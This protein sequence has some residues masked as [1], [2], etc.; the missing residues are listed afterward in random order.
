MP[1]LLICFGNAV[2]RIG[3]ELPRYT[4][5]ELD[6]DEEID[7]TFVSPTNLTANGPIYLAKEDNVRSEQTFRII[8]QAADSVP[9]NTQNINPATIGVDYSVGVRTTPVVEFL[10]SMQKVNFKF[11]LRA[12]NIPEGTEAFRAS[13]SSEDTAEVDGMEIDLPDYLPPSTL[14]AETFVIIEDDECKGLYG[15]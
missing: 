4:Y 10:P 2:I 11:T 7:S 9:P 15:I 3:F 14:S 12:D 5:M 6:F 13:S 1:H 8:V